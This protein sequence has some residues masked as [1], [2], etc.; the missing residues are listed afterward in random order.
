MIDDPNSQ[1]LDIDHG[2]FDIV[3]GVFARPWF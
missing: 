1:D 2:L 3:T